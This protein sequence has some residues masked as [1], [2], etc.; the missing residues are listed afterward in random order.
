[1][2]SRIIAGVFLVA[3]HLSAQFT[4]IPGG[5]GGGG[6][7]VSDV[8]GTANKITVSPTTGNV[9]VTIADVLNLGTNTSTIPWKTGT[10]PPATCSVGMVFYDTDAA[11][12]SQLQV[13]TAANT[14][15]PVGCALPTWVGQP[16]NYV[17]GVISNTLTWIPQ[18]GSGGGFEYQWT[19]GKTQAGVPGGNGSFGVPGSVGSPAATVPTPVSYCPTGGGC[20]NNTTNALYSVLQFVDTGT[21]S[22]FDNF[23]LPGS[24]PAQIDAEFKIQTIGTN[25][26]TVT[27]RIYPACVGAGDSMDVTYGAAQSVN[28]TPTGT[29]RQVLQGTLSAIDISTCSGNDKLMF[30][31]DRNT[32][33]AGT[34]AAE[35]IS[36]RFHQ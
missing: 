6:G 22:V 21:Q 31:V 15:T 27:F 9:V 34:D 29:A 35:L 30:K 18:S 13:C 5:G 10:T 8:T 24:L 26:G 23:D 11:S 16:D 33:D 28:F 1:M 19:A 4:P 32:G 2:I 25:T 36:I 7:A 3:L 12:S 20:D 14:W 17:L